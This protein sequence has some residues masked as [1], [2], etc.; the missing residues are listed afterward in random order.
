MDQQGEKG[1]LSAQGESHWEAGH[2]LRLFHGFMWLLAGLLYIIVWEAACSPGGNVGKGW[3]MECDLNTFSRRKA[4]NSFGV[5]IFARSH[6]RQ[7]TP[8]FLC[9]KDLAALWGRMCCLVQVQNM[10]VL[11]EIT[12]IK[13]SLRQ[14]RQRLPRISKLRTSTYP[15]RKEDSRQMVRRLDLRKICLGV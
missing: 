13:A 2:S 4:A 3:P 14:F 8:V 11:V 9:N 5:W 12:R 10:E 1:C 15:G 6:R 7:I